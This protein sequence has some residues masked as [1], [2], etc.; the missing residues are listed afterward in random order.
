MVFCSS[1]GCVGRSESDVVVYSALDQEFAQPILD[2]YER[3]VE[4]KTKVIGKFDVEST[5]TVGLVN[6]IVAEKEK[7][8]CD[9]FWNN[10][11]MHTV[12]LQKMGLLEPRSWKVQSGYPAN[13][14]AS[15]G[16][17]CG[18][19]A[20]ARVL[21]VNKQ[22]IPN[23]DDYPQSV[24]DL[25]DPK[26]KG[27]CAMA[28]PLFGTTATHFAVLRE[29]VGRDATIEQLK[30]IRDNATILSGNK[31][32]AMS[33][34]AGS[35]AWGLTDTDDAIIEKDQGRPVEIIFPDQATDQPGTLRIPNTI[36]VIK[37]AE[38]P[39]AAAA[40]ADFL[41]RPE[42]EDRLAMGES[43]QMPLSRGSKFPPRVLPS[44]PVRWMNADFESAADDWKAWAE[45]LQTIFQ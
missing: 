9:L 45:Q 24:A 8:T 35:V 16:T 29:L 44:E 42:T 19:A 4:G 21:I 36:A 2:S 40:L 34:S 7:P 11:I 20:R 26:W 39:N 6:L 33:V 10:E 28:R 3:S 38:H 13:M 27:K 17:W 30:A 5:K 12:R 22:L 32:V 41:I 15:D 37:N 18:F 31:Q 23:P 25:A 14:M 1:S 43:S